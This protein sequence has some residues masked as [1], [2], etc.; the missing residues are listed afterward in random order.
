MMKCTHPVLFAILAARTLAASSLEWVDHDKIRAAYFYGHRSVDKAELLERQGFNTMILKCPVD[1]AMPW[2]KEA[3]RLGMKC[4]F[5]CNFSVDARKAKLRR[6]VLA[7]GFV[8]R[9]ACPI[10]ERFWRDHLGKTVMDAVGRSMQPD[11]EITGLWIDF[12]LYHEQR[13]RYYTT[14]ACYCDHCFAEFLRSQ[15]RGAPRV[16]PAERQTWLRGQEVFDQ[17]H[18]FLQS[19]VEALA[20]ELRER[21]HAANPRFLLGFY[22]TP[23][24]WSL[25]GVAR[26]L[27]T[28][29]MPI[30]VWATDTYGGG[31]PTRVPDD[32]RE[33]FAKQGIH[34][35]YCAGMLLRCYSATNLA[36][37][38]YLSSTKCD[39]YWL[40]TTY[41][42][43][44]M[45]E[46][47]GKVYYLASGTPEEY[48]AAIKEANDALAQR[49]R[50]GDAYQHTFQFKPEP[51]GFVKPG[52][53]QPIDTTKLIPP[54]D[55][56]SAKL[57]DAEPRGTRQWLFHARKGQT[58]R[59][60]LA[61]R[62]VGPYKTGLSYTT[63]APDNQI[64]GQGQIELAQA[65]VVAFQA[66]DEGF[67]TFMGNA[68][69]CSFSVTESNVPISMM[70]RP[71]LRMIRKAGPLY[72]YV[73]KGIDKFTIGIQGGGGRE[74]AKLTVFSPNATSAASVSLT[75]VGMSAEATVAT[76]GHDAAVWSIVVSKSHEG[77]LED[78]TLQLD[79]KLPPL[80]AL[81]PHHVFRTAP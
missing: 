14:N 42:L 36:A 5:A 3:K 72:F 68:G 8:E 78:W 15:G 7:D 57:S 32:W 21:I 10:E 28:E 75:K 37:H 38:L 40:F 20:A 6:A 34:A 29:A 74:T 54:A 62:K 23:K 60:A 55:A 66:S 71:K 11:V 63:F 76:K 17:Y 43:W 31:G 73:P 49:M 48:W 50:L 47:R 22:P 51:T 19:R 18:P 81:S 41:T 2:A 52:G 26:G 45:P 16:A 77:I 35:R 59:I 39:G 80:V 65:G 33:S 4:F 27:S 69:S 1:K 12:E 53:P 67:Y 56:G 13:A 46:K 79:P 25:I 30:I 24:N 70:V 64:V 61:H 58:V 44:T 9:Y